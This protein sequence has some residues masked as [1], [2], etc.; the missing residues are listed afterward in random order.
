[1]AS[2]HAI[3]RR[4]QGMT[5]NELAIGLAIAAIMIGIAVPSMSRIATQQRGRETAHLLTGAFELARSEAIRTGDIHL[6]FLQTDA[7]G[8]PLLD[9]NGDP[10]NLV[11]LDDGAPGSANQNCQI[12]AGEIVAALSLAPDVALGLDA[13]VG[14]ATVDLG[15]GA[16]VGASSFSDP[17][18]N[19]AQW[20][21]FR[22]EG[23]PLAFDAACNLGPTGSGAGAFYLNAGGRDFAALL[24]PLGGTRV[25]AWDLDAGAWSN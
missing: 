22:P 11:V 25:D 19:P 12:D 23:L 13:A 6:V 16:L 5:L 17:A 2:T 7:N 15:A 3:A 21:A 1:M 20:V 14:K 9:E 4:Q 18:V 10:T 8:N 24:L